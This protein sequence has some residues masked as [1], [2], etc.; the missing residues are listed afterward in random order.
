M[1]VQCATH[2]VQSVEPGLPLLSSVRAF[3]SRMGHRG[4]VQQCLHVS[5][6]EQNGQIFTLQ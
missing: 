5:A 1:G 2:Q 4:C 6:P 3:R